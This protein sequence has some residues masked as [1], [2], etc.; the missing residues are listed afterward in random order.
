MSAVDILHSLIA[1]V[2]CGGAFTLA[3]SRWP[4][5]ERRVA[6]YCW[7]AH[8]AGAFA[9]MGVYEV[10]YGGG[11]LVYYFKYGRFLARYV[12]YDWGGHFPD[13]VDLLIQ[14]ET[15]LPFEINGV[16]SSTG[17]MVAVGAVIGLI[18]PSSW[19]GSVLVSSLAAAGQ[20][21]LWRGVRS[22][23]PP[24]RASIALWAVMTVPSV[25][26]WSSSLLKEAM[27]LIGIGFVVL[28]LARVRATRLVSGGGL[29]MLGVYIIGLF[30]A[31]ILFPL[32]IA[33]GVYM[34]WGRAAS[35]GGVRFRPVVLIAGAGLTIVLLAVLGEVFPRYSVDQVSESI[36]Q[37]Q[38][39]S[40]TSQG[41]SNFRES[42]P[43]QAPRGAAGL[44]ADAPFTVMTALFRPFVFEAR[45]AMMFV[46]SLETAVILYFV[47][48]AFVRIGRVELLRWAWRSPDIL[49]SVTFVLSFSFAVGLATTN[50]GTLSRYRLPMMPFYIYVVAAAHALPARRDARRRAAAER[51]RSRGETLVEGV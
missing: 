38:M 46:N 14:R 27:A 4:E 42:T 29:V 41:G 17:S 24:E 11:D 45:G 2:V 40:L 49:A 1:M 44:I 39:A 22:V 31:Y 12:E 21:C 34:Y 6:M 37:Q 10:Y 30:K 9:I 23:V 8:A 43:N 51:V 50:L 26:F 5:E 7:V 25:V 47:V 28:G 16:G 19:A 20:A 36:E 3:V 32:A 18:T 33:F 15:V 48:M 35:H 13:L